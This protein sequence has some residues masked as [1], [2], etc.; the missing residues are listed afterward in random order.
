MNKEE[1]WSRRNSKPRLRGQGDKPD[2]VVRS[3]TPD[4]YSYEGE[5]QKFGLYKTASGLVKKMYVNRAQRRA[6]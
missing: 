5:K 2:L 3:L 6:K 1:Y 4:E